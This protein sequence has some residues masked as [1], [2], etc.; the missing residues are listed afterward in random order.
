MR[1]KYR[2]SMQRNTTYLPFG[3]NAILTLISGDITPELHMVSDQGYNVIG[4]Y[5]VLF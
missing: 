1:D 3:A 2:Y 5:A 4:E